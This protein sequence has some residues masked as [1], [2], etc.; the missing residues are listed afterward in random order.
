MK[1]RRWWR[2]LLPLALAGACAALSARVYE[3]WKKLHEPFELPQ[4]AGE[5]PADLGAAP[6]GVALNFPAVDS[7]ASIAE[8][9]LFSPTRRPAE[10][11][12]TAPVVT[13]TTEPLTEFTLT[14]AVVSDG[15][16][17]VLLR[18]ADGGQDISV[19]EGS[20]IQGWTVVGIEVDRAVFRRGET[21]TT[22]VLHPSAVPPDR[23]SPPHNP[24]QQPVSPATNQQPPK[25]PAG[26]TSGAPP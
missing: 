22:L 11:A 4:A 24:P 2:A 6:G 8:R 26:Q 19:A 12:P 21:E 3:E 9:P 13:E 5:A 1:R 25:L 10:N 18:P 16:R 23:M 7:L 14:G 15:Q 20:A 17:Y